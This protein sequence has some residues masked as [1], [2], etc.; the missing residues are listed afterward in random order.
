MKP[1]AALPLPLLLLLAAAACTPVPKAEKEQAAPPPP[2]AGAAAAKPAAPEK[3]SLRRDLESA[4]N[5]GTGA[6]QMKAYKKAKTQI[7]EI[8][9]DQQRQLREALGE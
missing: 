2:A 9:A 5:Y 4:V 7:Q 3:E 6:T 1:R 8:G